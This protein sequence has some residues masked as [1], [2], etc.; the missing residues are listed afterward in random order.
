VGPVKGGDFLDVILSKRC[1]LNRDEIVSLVLDLML[2]G[3]ETTATL[4]SLIV[5]FLG[6]SPNALQKLEVKIPLSLD[7]SMCVIDQ[8]LQK[9]ITY[10]MLIKELRVFFLLNMCKGGT[11]R[12]KEKQRGWGTFELGRL[13]ENGVHLQCTLLIFPQHLRTCTFLN[14]YIYIDIELINHIYIYI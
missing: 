6:H 13:Q 1:L 2:G 8:C 12:D 9:M 4:M 10:V 14:D 5:Y 7:L 11:P 3:Y